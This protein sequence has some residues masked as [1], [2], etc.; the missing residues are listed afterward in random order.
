[1]E[2]ESKAEQLNAIVD[3]LLDRDSSQRPATILGMCS[4]PFDS[5]RPNIHDSKKEF[6]REMTTVETVTNHL[7]GLLD[8]LVGKSDKLDAQHKQMIDRLSLAIESGAKQKLRNHQV[9][10]ASDLA[11]KNVVDTGFY[12]NSLLLLIDML[13]VYQQRLTELMDQEKQF[14]SIEVVLPFRTVLRLG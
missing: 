3:R 10:T 9:D 4:E 14:W 11:L 5:S 13:T 7:R 6:I 12:Y 2:T 8:Q 1:M